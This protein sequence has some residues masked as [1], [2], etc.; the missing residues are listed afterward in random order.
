MSARETILARIRSRLPG[1]EA[2]RRE[3]V[4]L[5]LAAH[6]ANLVP[7]R[8]LGD[9]DHRL[10]LFTRLMTGVGGSVETVET[11]ADVVQAVAAHMAAAGLPPSLRKGADTTLAHL[12]WHRAPGLAL[13]SGPADPADHT[14]LSLAF[15][16]VAES[17]TVLLLSGPD[18]PA[19]LNF[20]P[21][22]H[23]VVL[24]AS[25]LVSCYEDVWPLLRASQ[26]DGLMPSTL[27]MISG[28]SRTADIEQTIVRPAHG[29]RD[30]HVII[31]LGA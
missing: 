10:S 1:T 15:A 4:E 6:G 8:G 13:L 27:N 5:H 19:T 11:L 9:G 23:M 17:G 16:G 2:A 12:P 26:G 31:V 30:L 28:P 25:R 20:L 18:N 7:L 21:E 24:P 22:L 29:P 3:E 14:T